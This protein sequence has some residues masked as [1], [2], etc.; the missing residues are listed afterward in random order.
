[1]DTQK[2]YILRGAIALAVA[3]II[4]ILVY[5]FLQLQFFTQKSEESSQKDSDIILN[6]SQEV[7]VSR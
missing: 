5:V 4:V 3:V 7:K 6:E 2:T 1:M